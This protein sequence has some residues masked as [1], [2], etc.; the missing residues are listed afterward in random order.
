[1]KTI[2]TR[3][4]SKLFVQK[5]YSD[6]EEFVFYNK[7]LKHWYPLNINYEY[8][9]SIDKKD[10]YL[11]LTDSYATRYD[12]GI[13]SKKRAKEPGN[14]FYPTQDWYNPD[15][16]E[17]NYRISKLAES[18]DVV[19]FNTKVEDITVKSLEDSYGNILEKYDDIQNSLFE[20]AKEHMDVITIRHMELEERDEYLYNFVTKEELKELHDIGK[21]YV[22]VGLM[23]KVKQSEM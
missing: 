13:E 5:G 19:N 18:I 9:Y 17:D 1:M 23:E 2:I 16:C 21:M 8:K 6:V 20:R 11:T 3:E 10:I 15:V 14:R 12:Y 7:T 22:M 4:R